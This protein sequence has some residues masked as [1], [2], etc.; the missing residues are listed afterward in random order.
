MDL[1]KSLES[2]IDLPSFLVF[3]RLLAEDKAEAVRKEASHPSHFAEVDAGGWENTSIDGFLQAA[4]S[5]AQ[6]TEMGLSQ[7]LSPDNPWKRFAT[8]LYCGKIYE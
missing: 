2:V 1:A 3:V 4:A 7:G 8:F 5:W 6:D